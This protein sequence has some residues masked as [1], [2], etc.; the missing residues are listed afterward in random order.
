M[1]WVW[2]KIE[3]IIELIT[4]RDAEPFGEAG[5]WGFCESD[6]VQW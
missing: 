5:W 4:Y 1:N 2:N 3:D 6:F